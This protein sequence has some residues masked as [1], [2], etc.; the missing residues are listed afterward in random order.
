MKNI[1]RET[2]WRWQ[3]RWGS[4]KVLAM[5]IGGLALFLA[6][7][8][9]WRISQ[10]DL[11]PAPV[12]LPIRD[13]TDGG[14]YTSIQVSGIPLYD[15]HTYREVDRGGRAVADYYLLRDEKWGRAVW[16]RS[17]HLIE[18]G[19]VSDV[20]T[21]T[22]VLEW[23]WKDE[24]PFLF[25]GSVPVGQED[26]FIEKDCYLAEGES[27][28]P[29]LGVVTFFGFLSF[30]GLVCGT[31]LLCPRGIFV[32]QSLPQRPVD[33]RAV[34]GMRVYGTFL[35]LLRGVPEPVF[36]S[37]T[38]GILGVGVTVHELSEQRLFLQLYELRGAR[39]SFIS[40]MNVGRGT[41]IMVDY[42]HRGPQSAAE[43]GFSG[44]PRWGI[45][46]E[47]EKITEATVGT[48]FG[49][50]DRWAV[51]LRYRDANGTSRWLISAFERWDAYQVFCA[52]LEARGIA[53][54]TG[55]STGL[56][57]QVIRVG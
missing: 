35:R 49:W 12:V 24:A 36:A 30:I 38:R 57:R 53:L 9:G 22:G 17:G 20:V 10:M 14:S 33:Y 11:F 47:P 51:F 41:V 34:I 1:R 5:W 52:L 4:W 18:A 55:S 2:I 54:T 44:E 13:V 43:T 8:A 19:Q 16:V 45:L 37:S 15:F 27:S 23:V 7:L 48:L 3:A 46:L 6:L 42:P 25:F 39:R 21:I 56:P 29:S 50:K 26:L 32:D 28:D 40:R 31:T